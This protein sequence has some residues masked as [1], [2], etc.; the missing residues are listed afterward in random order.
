MEIITELKRL[1]DLTT[2]EINVTDLFEDQPAHMDDKEL[3]KKIRKGDIDAFETLFRRYYS[4]LYNYAYMFVKQK[5]DAE[6]IV[7]D[8][9]FTIWKNKTNLNISSSFKSY[10]YRSVYNNSV[11]FLR[12][13]H[14]S[15][16]LEEG[17]TEK[18]TGRDDPDSVQLQQLT[19]TIENVLRSLP[20][21]SRRIFELS[22]FEGL[23]YHE[24]AEKLAISIKTVE[25]NMSK[26]LKTFRKYLREYQNIILLF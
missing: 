18:N 11:Q 21:R 20:E 3:L 17:D 7:Q 2:N 1:N 23:R 4:A 10:V 19:E 6:E 22:R 25:A 26:V 5:D 8:L 14:K 9:F 13:K 24:I 15:V 16:S 12:R